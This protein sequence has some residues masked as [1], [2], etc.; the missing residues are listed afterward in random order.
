MVLMVF[1]TF[2][3]GRAGGGVCVVDAALRLRRHRVL[4]E[5]ILEAFSP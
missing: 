5:A 1:L 2:F 3:D 4:L